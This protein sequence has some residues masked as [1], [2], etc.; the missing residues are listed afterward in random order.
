[1]PGDPARRQAIEVDAGGPETEPDFAT[2]ARVQVT[3]V[4]GFEVV[5]RLR[6]DPVVA[7]IPI[8]VLTA[9][10]VTAADHERL[11]GRISFLARKGEF[12]RAELVALVGSLAGVREAR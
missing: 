10:H 5:D 9:R 3:K 4:D 1:M 2:D 7:D 12:G 11:T 6:S 8:V